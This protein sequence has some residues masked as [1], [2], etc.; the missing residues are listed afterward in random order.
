MP[1]YTNLRGHQVWNYEWANNG[2]ALVMLHGGMS[3]TEDWDKYMLPA[4]ESTHHVF[5]YDRTGQGRQRAGPGGVPQHG[6]RRAGREHP[7]AVQRG[8]GY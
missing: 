3:A 5:A 6:D 8:P 2:E 1:S 7:C 4:F